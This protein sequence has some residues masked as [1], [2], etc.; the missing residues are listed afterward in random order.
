MMF[1][2]PGSGATASGFLVPCPFLTPAALP[3]RSMLDARLST[4]AA[5]PDARCSMCAQSEGR[6][7]H[8]TSVLSLIHI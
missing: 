1:Q 7:S 2:R 3:P 8:G 5:V 4:L 6:T